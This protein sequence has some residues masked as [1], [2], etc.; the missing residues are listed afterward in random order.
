MSKSS[1][2]LPFMKW[3]TADWRSDA[4]VRTLS[5]GAR[6]FWIELINIMHEADPYGFLLINGAKPDT[7]TLAKQVTMSVSEVRR[8]SKELVASAV[9]SETEIGVFFCRRMVRD[10][11]KRQQNREYG[12]LGGNPRLNP[13]LI[14]RVN[15]TVVST[16]VNPR[17]N[18]T[19]NPRARTCD[20]D[21]ETRD[22]RLE[23][24]DLC[25]PPSPLDDSSSVDERAGVFCRRYAELYPVHRH[26]AFY[27]PSPTIDFTEAKMLCRTW[28]DDAHLER[29]AVACPR[30]KTVETT[31]STARARSR[32]L[33]VAPAATT[34]RYVNK[35]ARTLERIPSDDQY[36]E[37]RI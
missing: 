24:R 15:P 4:G 25:T 17:D 32:N 36:R 34:S 8:Y 14:P 37:V 35:T 10:E 28:M 1:K 33:E 20:R 19:D 11:E 7:K 31:F 5:A 30:Q 18:P 3:Y 29:M 26:G 12:S 6:G 21:L 2:K 22:Q 16:G 9:V 27:R 13:R 23:T